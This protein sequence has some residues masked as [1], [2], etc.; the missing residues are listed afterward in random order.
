[1]DIQRELQYEQRIRDLEAENERLRISA[2][3]VV[4]WYNRDGS[5]GGAVDPMELLEEAL[6]DVS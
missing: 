5:V 4:E 6:N 1:M 2:K 3:A